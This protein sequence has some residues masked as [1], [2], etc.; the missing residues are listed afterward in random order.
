MI[1]LYQL[2]EF[3][4]R[5]CVTSKSVLQSRSHLRPSISNYLL[6]SFY[7]RN[8][9]PRRSVTM[10]L[11]FCISISLF[12]AYYTVPYHRNKTLRTIPGP[13]IAAFSNLWLFYHSR[14]GRRSLAVDEAHRKYGP[15]VRIQPNH[16]SIADPEALL[17]VYSHTGGWLKR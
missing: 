4:Q 10:L 7:L 11:L 15:L 16:V 9:S 2:P 5:S 6:L 17:I 13:K 12:L 1:S 3:Q 8:A 14:R